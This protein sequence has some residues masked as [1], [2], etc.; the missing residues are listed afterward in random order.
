MSKRTRPFNRGKKRRRLRT[1]WR[2]KR[3]QRDEKMVLDFMVNNL[4]RSEA[5]ACQRFYFFF[6]DP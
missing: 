3:R 4:L 5:E 2:W 1:H 6:A